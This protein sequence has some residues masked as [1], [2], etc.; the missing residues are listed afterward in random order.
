MSRI[1][2]TGLFSVVW[3]AAL[4]SCGKTDRFTVCSPD[5]KL[6]LR[7]ALDGQSCL[8]YSIVRNDSLLFQASP[9]GVFVADPETGYRVTA[10]SNSPENE[11]KTSDGKWGL[12]AGPTYDNQ[13]LHYLF[14]ALPSD[15]DRGSITGLCA[16]GGFVVD[17]Q[18]KDNSPVHTVIRSTWGHSA[19]VSFMGH[20]IRIDLEPGQS[21]VLNNRLEIQNG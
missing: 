12:C 3:L 11:F 20:K 8:F 18:W 2:L 17:M 10:P 19:G 5:G 15:W 21:I 13:L 14:A 16:R 1:C 9:L 7:V 6:A 4:F